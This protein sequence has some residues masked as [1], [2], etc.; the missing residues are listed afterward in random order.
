M[1]VGGP[2]V[3]LADLIEHSPSETFEHILITGKCEDNEIDYLVNNPLRTEVIYIDDI[4]RSVFLIKDLR[5]FFKLFLLL[6]ELRPD[7]VHTH[8]SKAGA[9][10]RLAASLA[11]PRAKIVH[12]FHGHLLHGY[13]KPFKARVIVF[14]ERILANLSENLIAVSNQTKNDL[15][16]RGVGLRNEWEVIHPGIRNKVK[17]EKVRLADGTF[18][19]AWVGRFADI[20]NPILA[21]EAFAKAASNS[22]EK[23]K[24]VMAGAGE[25]LDECKGFASAHGLNVDFLG[26]TSDVS[27][28]LSES[29]LLLFTSRNEGFGMVVV[30]AALQR[31]P[32]IST[33]SGGVRDFIVHSQTGLIAKADPDSLASAINELRLNGNMRK[34]LASNAYELAVTEYSADNYNTKHFKLYKSLIN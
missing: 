5:S 7:I 29:D 32:T 13:F 24:L 12:T 6:R 11:T 23:L 21:L 19:I 33:D 18:Q 8:T 4:Q 26:W 30:E 28:L 25:L 1:N 16:A 22:E 31:I 14:L 9:I 27:A 20:K 10:G 34:K 3:L 2:A 15:L 17:N